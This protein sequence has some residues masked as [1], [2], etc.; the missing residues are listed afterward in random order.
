MRA[1]N[2]S[3]AGLPA[4]QRRVNLLKDEVERQRRRGVVAALLPYAAPRL[5]DELF[6]C[7]DEHQ[8]KI[9]PLPK[10]Y[11]YQASLYKRRQKH[12]A[13]SLVP[14]PRQPMSSE[15]LER[16]NRGGRT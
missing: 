14:L 10:P 6:V 7:F 9:M 16:N 2:N 4:L 12:R 5:P 13:E 8:R 1:S 3:I 11:A 15:S